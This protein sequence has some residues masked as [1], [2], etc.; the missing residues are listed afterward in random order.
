MW[1]SFIIFS[2]FFS[3]LHHSLLFLVLRF[4]IAFRLPIDASC[5]PSLCAVLFFFLCFCFNKTRASP[6]MNRHT[7]IIS[8]TKQ[9]NDEMNNKKINDNRNHGVC[10]IVMMMC[11]NVFVVHETH[12]QHRDKHTLITLSHTLR[13]YYIGMFVACVC[14]TTCTS[15]YCPIQNIYLIRKTC[16]FQRFCS[17]YL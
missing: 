10:T 9:R 12:I 16:K 8:W 2:L 11:E 6:P 17:L 5:L 1:S 13:Q 4:A 14:M 7:H 15:T 3:L